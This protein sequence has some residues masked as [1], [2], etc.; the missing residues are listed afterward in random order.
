MPEEIK[1]P[2]IGTQSDSASEP[3]KETIEPYLVD[4]NNIGELFD[5][6]GFGRFTGDCQDTI[7]IWLKVRDNKIIKASFWT[8]G[9]PST[10]MASDAVCRLANSK[11]VAEALQ[12]T[13]KDV[14]EYLGGLPEDSSH[15]A[16]LAVNTLKSAIMDYISRAKEP[17]WKMLYR[18][19]I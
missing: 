10:I 17:P 3:S 1:K 4:S 2:Q 12:I 19:K 8:N 14:I 9:C 18:K 15:C 11:T 6:D 16:A 7:E 5:A 13:P